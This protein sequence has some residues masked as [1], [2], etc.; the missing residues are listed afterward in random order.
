LFL[1]KGL[2]ALNLPFQILFLVSGGHSVIEHGDTFWVRRFYPDGPSRQ[3]AGRDRK[4]SC[5]KPP[6]GSD[7][8][9]PLLTSP[10]RELHG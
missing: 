9:D 6:P 3:W 1:G 10:I 2:K 8:A 7:I 4:L 5:P